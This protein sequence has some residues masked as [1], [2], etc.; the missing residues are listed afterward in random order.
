MRTPLA[1]ASCV[2]VF[3]AL[4]TLASAAFG[5]AAPFAV[6][7]RAAAP[8]DY[9]VEVDLDLTHRATGRTPAGFAHRAR[10]LLDFVRVYLARR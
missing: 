5:A 2:G 6:H 8:A 7:V 4:S 10:Q 1:V 3:A 9:V